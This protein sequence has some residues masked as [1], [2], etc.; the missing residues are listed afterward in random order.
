[1]GAKCLLTIR[2]GVRRPALSL[3]K[4]QNVVVGGANRIPP[5]GAL[6]VLLACIAV[7]SSQQ[8]KVGEIISIA[9]VEFGLGFGSIRH[10]VE[11]QQK[12][13]QYIRELVHLRDGFFGALSVTSQMFFHRFMARVMK[14]LM[15]FE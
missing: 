5:S 15:G 9:C 1:M 13:D 3:T 11:I 10:F 8:T 4:P 12:A 6:P 7:N 2:F 14:A